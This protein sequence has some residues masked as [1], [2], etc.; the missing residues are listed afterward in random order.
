MT[1]DRAWGRVPQ[2]CARVPTLTVPTCPPPSCAPAVAKG[3]SVL[4][5][6]S[7]NA[8]RGLLMHLLKIPTEEIS[9]IEIPTGLPLIFDMRYKCLKLL[10]GDF[11]DYNFGKGADLLF[12]PCEIPDDEYDELDLSPI[13]ADALAG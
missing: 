5:A 8:I 4:V 3:K 11:H 9:N 13:E 12:T 7:E 10:E 2:P 1:E 6:S